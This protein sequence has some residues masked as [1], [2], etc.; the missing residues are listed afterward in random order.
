MAAE[1]VPRFVDSLL[2]MGED[3]QLVVATRSREL[4]AAAQRVVQLG[5][6]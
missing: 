4:A 1:D 2:R 5:A 6:G 3:N